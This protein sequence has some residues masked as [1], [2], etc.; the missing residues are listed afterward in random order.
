VIELHHPQADRRELERLAQWCCQFSPTVGLE[1]ADPPET[2]LLD[3]T[4][5]APLY[6]GEA[7]LAAQVRRACQRRGL[8]VRLAVADTIGAAWALAHYGA[9]AMK[10]P[11]IPFNAL[12]NIRGPGGAESCSQGRKAL[13]EASQ[14]PGKPQ[15]GDI[16]DATSDVAPSGLPNQFVAAN[17]E[18]APLATR[19][20]PAGAADARKAPLLGNELAPLPIAALRLPADLL[21]TLADL[22]IQCVGELLKLP[23]EQLQSRLGSLVLL[24]IDQALGRAEEV[25]FPIDPPPDFAVEHAY[26]YPIADAA[27][28]RYTVEQLLK[29]LTLLLQTRSAGALRLRCRLDCESAPPVAFEFDLFQPTARW[30]HLLELLDMH[31][32]RVRLAAPA[33]AVEL[34][35]VRHAP[36]AE[37][38]CQLFE[39]QRELGSSHALATLIDRLAGRLGSEAVVRCAVVPE[40]QPELAFRETALSGSAPEPLKRILARHEPIGE[41]PLQRSGSAEQTAQCFNRPLILL[42]RPAPLAAWSVAPH[43]PPTHFQHAGQQHEVARHWGPE[44][45]ETGWW[46]RA[47][48]WRDYYRVETTAGRRFWLFRRRRDG[49]WFLHGSYE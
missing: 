38:Q 37:R 31:L 2:L 26:E 46:R 48:A 39:Q 7:A 18:L 11:C 14:Y 40:A 20:R 4:N 3:V 22:G 30:R 34:C 45:I 6:G 36:L 25:F 43:G 47:S 32:E 21:A 27:A 49:K 41:D 5:L 24:R 33:V 16:D 1:D 44:R 19:L 10:Q 12:E 28:I 15:R 23:R 29:R 35:A 17:Q 8:E 13:V 9:K 42:A